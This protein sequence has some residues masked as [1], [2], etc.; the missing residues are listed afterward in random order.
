MPVNDKTNSKKF[1]NK[2]AI[3]HIF[4]PKSWVIEKAG[5]IEDEN[6]NSVTDHKGVFAD[7]RVK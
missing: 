6:L 4:I 1:S 7:V 5:L 3:D 2:T